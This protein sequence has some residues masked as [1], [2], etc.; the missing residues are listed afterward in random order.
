VLVD[1]SAK[2]SR[3]ELIALISSPDLREDLV[4]F[5]KARSGSWSDA[6]DFVNQ[7]IEFVLKTEGAGWDRAKQPTLVRYMASVV[8]RLVWAHRTSARERLES[9]QSDLA[10]ERCAS[11]VANPEEALLNREEIEAERGQAEKRLNALNERLQSEQTPTSELALRVLALELDGTCKP[12]EQAG[13]LDVEPRAVYRCRELI[14]KCI[15][16][17]LSAER[18]H[19]KGA[20]R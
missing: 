4:H 1:A 12:R 20:K 10:L 17:I 15:D 18:E 2:V 14:L 19:G 6:Q 16:D 3:E 7:A 13:K 5:A 8:N 11:S 9:R